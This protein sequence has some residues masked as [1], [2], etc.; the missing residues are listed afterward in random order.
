MFKFVQMA[1]LF[2]LYFFGSFFLA[3][4]NF[5]SQKR[6]LDAYDFSTSAKSE[7]YLS[8]TNFHRDLDQDIYSDEFDLADEDHVETEPAVTLRLYGNTMM[9]YYYVTM[10]FGSPLQRQNLIVDTGSTI[11]TIPCTGIIIYKS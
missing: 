3:R 1:G 4:C 9:G 11:T 10:F 7:R 6:Q 8:S 2:L 5:V